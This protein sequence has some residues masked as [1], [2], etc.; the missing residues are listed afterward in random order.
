MEQLP[1]LRLVSNTLRALRFAVPFPAVLIGLSLLLGRLH[2]LA[3]VVEGRCTLRSEGA[4]VL[5]IAVDG[6]EPVEAGLRFLGDTD[7]PLP[8]VSDVMSCPPEIFLR[9]VG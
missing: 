1:V 9:A 3:E 4:Y 6:N 2:N 5:P 8:I 7:A